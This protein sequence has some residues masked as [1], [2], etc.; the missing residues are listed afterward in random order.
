MKYF[1]PFTFVLAL[2][3]AGAATAAQT[4]P[5]A[6]QFEYTPRVRQEIVLPIL[7]QKLG[8]AYRFY[9]DEKPGVSMV[10]GTAQLL[11]LPSKKIDGKKLAFEEYFMIVLDACTLKVVR[12]YL[13]L[14]PGGGY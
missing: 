11:F 2:I 13:L 5:T 8:D 10:K 14:P 12:S 3:C 6:C 1:I 9:D 4:A 7:R